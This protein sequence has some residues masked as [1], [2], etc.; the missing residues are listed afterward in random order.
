MH[1]SSLEKMRSFREI[2]LVPTDSRP[3]RVLDVGAM[4]HD[5]QDSYR[6]LFAEGFEYV[7]LDLDKAPNVDIAPSDPYAWTELKTGIFDAVI[8]GQTFEHNPYPWITMA[9]FARV[10]R[11]DGMVGLIAPS[12]GDVHRFPLDC[13]RFYPDAASAL[14]TYVGLELVESYVEPH[15]RA[16]DGAR[17]GGLLSRCT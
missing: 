4:A 5:D 16:V 6:P 13:W 1:E 2:Y 10:L 14:C 9:E 17:W 8:S 7:G 15:D 12:R 11:P 3:I